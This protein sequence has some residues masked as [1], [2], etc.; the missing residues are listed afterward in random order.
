MSQTGEIIPFKEPRA[1]AGD[2]GG[3]MSELSSWKTI[4]FLSALCAV[5]ATSS[6]AQTFKTLVS[7]NATDG[8]G[9]QYAS[10]VQGFDGKLYG[11]TTEN[12]AYG[13]GSVFKVTPKRMLTTLY[14]FCAQTGC[15]DGSYPLAGLVLASNGTFYGTT[16]EGGGS[17]ACNT[18]GSGCGTV[19]KITAGGTL[20]TLHSFDGTDGAQPQAPL[21]QATNGNFY[22]TTLIGGTNSCIMGGVNLGCGTVF[23]IT[24]GGRLTTLHSFDGTDGEFPLAGLV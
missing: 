10:L 12:G 20:T 16:E 6:P 1:L 17:S 7:F 8:S 15:N 11:T 22:G 24:P 19:F 4:L 23:E 14:S 18:Y 5:D 9:P 2:L 21:V 3:S 13:V